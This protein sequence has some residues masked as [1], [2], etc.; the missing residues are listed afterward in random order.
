MSHPAT[1]PRPEAIHFR[2][3]LFRL[4]V[5]CLFAIAMFAAF[6]Y[7]V[8]Q[9]AWYAIPGVIIA[10]C[11][12]SLLHGGVSLTRDGITW[13]RLH[14]R[15]TYRTVPWTAIHDVSRGRFGIGSSIHLTVAPGRYEAWIWGK[16]VR[17]LE[18]TINPRELTDG[19]SLWSAIHHFWHR[20]RPIRVTS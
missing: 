19:E 12:A 7:H 2:R 3:Q 11:F 5:P 16:P 8:P 13:Y 9:G 10:V 17:E 20:Q 1:D 6:A 4:V 18:I 15:F 14:P